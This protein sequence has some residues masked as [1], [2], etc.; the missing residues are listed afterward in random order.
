MSFNYGKHNY[1]NKSILN[2]KN[3]VIREYDMKDGGFSIIKSKKLLSDKEILYLEGLPKMER[4][5]QIGKISGKDKELGKA[6]LDG[7]TE[8]RKKFLDENNVNT[9]FV[10]SVKKDAIYL[11]NHLA[12]VT[13]FDGYVFA[14]KNQYS[15]Y[16]Y[17]NKKEF[18]YSSWEDRLDVKGI[19]DEVV[20]KHEEYFLHTI[21]ELMKLNEKQD[22]TYMVNILKQVRHEYLNLELD[23]EYYR[24]MN[25]EN[26]YRLKYIIGDALGGLEGVNDERVLESV[27]IS[28]N[29]INYIIP[30]IGLII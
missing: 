3:V 14:L 4:H 16:Y 5:I 23:F 2:L 11:I 25:A 29:Y 1:L 18:Y 27:D 28:Y 24:E 7:F 9:D 17:I 20:K 10:L 15:S 26:T 22:K 6:L 13:E 19:G 8:A 12:K 21:R 30:L